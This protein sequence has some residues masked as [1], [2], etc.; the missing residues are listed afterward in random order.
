[1][2]LTLLPEPVHA[3]EETESTIES[4]WE[5]EIYGDGVALTK[6][7]GTETDIY[8][9]STIEE[10]DKE[11]QVIK[12]GDDLFNNNDGLNSVTLGSGITEIGLRTFYDAD[13][14]TCIVT[15]E[16]LTIIEDEAFYSCD[17]FNSIILYDAVTTIGANAFSECENL[18]I[19][20]NENNAGHLYAMENEINY[21]LLSEDNELIIYTVDGVS[22]HIQ[23]GQAYAYDCDTSVTDVTIPASVEGYPVTEIYMEAFMD[24]T[25]LVN[26]HLTNGLQRINHYAF[27]NCT[28]L[29]S[30]EIPNSVV[31]LGGFV[32]FGC[33]SLLE[34]TLPNELTKL[35]NYMFSGCKNLANIKLPEGMTNIG[36]YAFEGCA[37]LMEV[38]I[39][40]SVTS[41]DANAFYGCKSL[42]NIVIPEGITTIASSTFAG[43]RSLKNIEIP[44][45]VTSI[46]SSAFSSCV[47]LETIVIPESVEQIG[48]RAFSHCTSLINVVFPEKKMIIETGAFSNCTALESIKIPEGN[49]TLAMQLF[50]KCSNLK[51][52]ILPNTLISIG[53]S[54]FAYCTGLETIEIPN[55]VTNISY[56]VFKGCSSLKNIKLSSGIS[57]ILENCFLDCTALESITIPGNVQWIEKNAFSGCSNLKTVVLEEGIKRI[58][59]Y[60]FTS[61][62]NLQTVHIPN[63]VNSAF[64]ASFSD[65][66]IFLVNEG[67]YAHTYVESSSC[68]YF[69]YKDGAEN[70]PEYYSEEGITYCIM[71][72]EAVAVDCDMNLTKV[73]IPSA[74][75][76]CTVKR[77]HKLFK[78]CTK[79]IS[80]EVPS[81]ITK[82]GSYTFY[83]CTNLT[84]VKLPESITEIGS[85]AF[86]DCQ[87]LT[88]IVLPNNITRIKWSAFKGCKALNEV[89]IPSGVTK[90]ETYAFSDCSGLRTVDI[91]SGVTKIEDYAF[92]WC[93]SL[94]EIIL[95]DGL[96]TIGKGAFAQCKN[97]SGIGIPESVTSLN[98]DSFYSKTIL[99][100]YENSYAH[101]FAE[102]N[103]V[104]YL[105]MTDETEPQVYEVDGVT[106]CIVSGEAVAIL[107]DSSLTSAVMPNEIA[108]CP[109]TRIRANA[110]NGC[111]GLTNITLSKNLK[112]IEDHAFYYCKA[113]IGIVLPDTI[114][115]IGDHAFSQCWSLRTINFPEGLSYIGES[116]FYSCGRLG[117]VV[118]PSSLSNISA[119][120]FMYCDGMG[121]IIIPENI[122]SV[123]Q[124]A[125]SHCRC[126]S[127]VVIYGNINDIGSNVFSWC[128]ALNEVQII[129]E[130][131]AI[132][133][134]MFEGCSKL[135]T[136]SIPD[137]ITSIY[138][139]AFEQCTSLQSMVLPEKVTTIGSSAFEDCTALRE[140]YMP[141][142]LQF[143]GMY[144]FMN[145]KNLTEIVLQDEI[146]EIDQQAFYNCTK[147][148]R[149]DLGNTQELG[150]NCFGACTALTE[151]TIPGSVNIMRGS[152]FAGC[153][154][155][156]E[157]VITEGAT[158][159]GSKTFL[160]CTGLTH[161]EIPGSVWNV[162]SEAFYGCVNIT[163][164][165]LDE[166]IQTIAGTAFASC[167]GVKSVLVP[168]SVSALST[169]S[170]ATNTI[171]IVYEGSYA[172]IY[173]QSNHLLYFVIRKTNNPEIAYGTGITGNVSYTD[174]TMASEVSVELLYD[175]GVT[176]ENIDT[177][178]EGA[179]G[180][181]YAEVGRYTIRV[182]DTWGNTASGRVSVKRMNVFQVFLQGDTDFV[183]KKSWKIAGTVSES[184]GTI[185]LT[186]ESG[187]ILQ[188]YDMTDGV[189]TFMDVSNGT[190]YVKAETDNGSVVQEVTVFESDI[191]NLALIINTNVVTIWG[192]VEVEDRE[193]RHHRRNWVEVTLYDTDGIVLDHCKSDAEG[194]YEFTKLPLGEYTIVAQT[195]EMRPDK[196]HHYERS[197]TLTGYA[198][199]DIV[200]AGIYQ[201]ETI[202]LYEESDSD[203][204]LSGKVTAH[205]E[206]QNCEVTLRNVFG[207]EIAA[208]TTGKNG[209]YNFKNVKDG[210]YFVTAITQSNGMG[211]TVIVVRN[212]RV[213]G[214]PHITVYKHDKIKN[215]EDRFKEEIPECTCRED[216][217]KYRGRIAEEK[218]F[219]D[220]LSHKEKKQCS[221]E[222]VER[223]NCY[224]EWLAN[225]EYI[226]D[227]GVQL[228]QGGLVVSG[229]ELENESELSFHL[230]VEKKDAW[231]ISAD[232]VHTEADYIYHSMNDATNG[233]ELI[234]YYEI[235]MSKT[236]DGNEKAITSVYKDTDAMGKFRVTIT[237]PEEY[238]GYKHY[239]FVHVHCGEIMALV[240]LDDDPDTV[241]FEVDRFSTFALAATNQPRGIDFLLGDLN[242]DG[243]LG[244]EDSVVMRKLLSN[245]M[246]DDSLV[247]DLNEDEKVDSKDLV[248]MKWLEKNNE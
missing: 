137:S 242:E 8:A 95:P 241:T 65:G 246:E 84:E 123:G 25:E 222:Y 211:Y 37:A 185:K 232:G 174:G 146:V 218:R 30:V 87:S 208:C 91:P 168:E 213:Y 144:A 226:V 196:K 207:H 104:L 169:N 68:L 88:E 164:V 79:L 114:T 41:I 230:T 217:L 165:K 19:W 209:K 80:V 96:E 7:N 35:T 221:K 59:D 22:Y 109:V 210:M 101:T 15:N 126:A 235:T 171:L 159:I 220:G 163:N 134:Y 112:V 140:I 23:N 195:A 158:V 6:Y 90:I 133:T 60:A 152:S 10:G 122:K 181:S 135:V 46:G 92:L 154:G 225:C 237:L 52:V 212:D 9:P 248:K 172:H 231:Q 116:A 247:K 24:C 227:E 67:S 190:Y 124:E 44:K 119:R 224:S 48:N 57:M 82:I 76:G 54:A 176:K 166:G 155:L 27:K 200:E 228:Q 105:I 78:N 187:N 132:G 12:L 63:S 136:I 223:L 191:T 156:K 139:G 89:K 38:V 201:A 173:A 179:Y 219:Y 115:Y 26:V 34:I 236:A 81:S 162:Q 151:I 62:T 167:P 18:T 103:G 229:A 108:G 61:T 175:D 31:T 145:C 148:S 194:R 130:M 42:T 73:K 199:M 142:D 40:E 214:N 5:Y 58:G 47:S 143:I 202:V 106:Y 120:A 51:N 197:H 1:M 100:V 160:G 2:F 157:V 29:Q 113:L 77:M 69:I 16:D 14:M 118:F 117:N 74:V 50:E 94:S 193:C 21:E 127:K 153:T 28:S 121:T 125:F 238:R 97:I 17:N 99:F 204:T 4:E 131:S 234:Q 203:M 110:F 66:T 170:F 149:L 243:T 53:D 98:T 86:Q 33:T 244:A 107:A 183:L 83:G 239:S 72:N 188:S 70:I 205:G 36:G 215:R 189:F 56:N 102:K 192:Y 85:Y 180:F 39:P 55:S 150:Y 45:S 93:T 3:A 178:D 75:N 240:D 11:Y 186:D 32:F 64:G 49:T 129:G 128:T 71:N 147:L 182:T 177:D 184:T 245:S 138:I 198:Y 233:C 111:S 20:C 216:V 43:C 161:I 13:N 206:P 141:K